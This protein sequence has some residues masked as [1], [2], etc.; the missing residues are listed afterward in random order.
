MSHPTISQAAIM[1][2][3]AL[4]VWMSGGRRVVRNAERT[5]IAV[6][7]SRDK[8]QPHPRCCSP[9]RAPQPQRQDPRGTTGTGSG[10]R[11]RYPALCVLPPGALLFPEPFAQQID[12]GLNLG[13]GRLRNRRSAAGASQFGVNECVRFPSLPCPYADEAVEEGALLRAR[14]EQRDWLGGSFRLS[15][16]ATLSVAA[17]LSRLPVA[18]QFG[19][20]LRLKQPG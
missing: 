6:R 14:A 17:L 12:A 18:Q 9:R 3:V 2:I 15:Q 1:A 8:T 16:F 7:L 11:G 20:L 10:T 5:P 4:A 13:H 19:N